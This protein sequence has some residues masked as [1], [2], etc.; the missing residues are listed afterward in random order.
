MA[1]MIIM[2]GLKLKTMG[3]IRIAAHVEPGLLL[4]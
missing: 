2:I 1:V 4:L 3:D